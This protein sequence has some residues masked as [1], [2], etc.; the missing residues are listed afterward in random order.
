MR[1]GSK[2]EWSLSEMLPGR[3]RPQD[4]L[5]ED[6]AHGLM[7]SPRTVPLEWTKQAEDELLRN[8]GDPRFGVAAA[9][10]LRE[11]RRVSA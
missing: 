9:G 11:A 4:V 5:G 1:D 10:A 2:K 8:A 6:Y 3:F 7:A